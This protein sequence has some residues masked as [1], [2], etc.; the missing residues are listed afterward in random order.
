M[1]SSNLQHTIWA[2]FQLFRAHA[3]YCGLWCVF[4]WTEKLI[5]PQTDIW[6][7][8]NQLQIKKKKKKKNAL[9]NRTD[10]SLCLLMIKTVCPQTTDLNCRFVD[11]QFDRQRLSKPKLSHVNKISC[12]T[13]DTIC[14]ILPFSML[15][16][17]AKLISCSHSIPHTSTMQGGV[18]ELSLWNLGLNSQTTASQNRERLMFSLVSETA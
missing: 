1:S 7:C 9:Q 3:A 14:A 17:R 8:N 11:L 13:I 12:L 2:S 6:A 4:S 5:R 18:L 15:G 16:L 10:K